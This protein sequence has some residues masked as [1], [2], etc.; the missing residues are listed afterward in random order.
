MY[1]RCFRGSQ[2]IC[3]RHKSNLRLYDRKFSSGVSEPSELWFRAS[4]N[5]HHLPTPSARTCC[6]CSSVSEEVIGDY[7][8]VA[9]ST[10]YALW[11]VTTIIC[12]IH[13]LGQTF[14][15]WMSPLNSSTSFC[16]EGE[17]T[18]CT[19]EPGWWRGMRSDGPLLSNCPLSFLF[20]Y[21][22]LN[23]LFVS[24]GKLVKMML[25]KRNQIW[26]FF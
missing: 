3:L 21:D 20:H 25:L 7:P 26:T 19:V 24:V 2:H 13:G 18:M 11:R 14:S 1:T 6:C 12:N 16:I 17:W 4:C 10:W 22:L 5:I 9:R 8:G 23:S 15:S